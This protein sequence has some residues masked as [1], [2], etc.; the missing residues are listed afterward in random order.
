[1]KKRAVSARLPDLISACPAAAS[2]LAPFD[3]DP[4][5]LNTFVALVNYQDRNA[6][7]LTKSSA[8]LFVA[9][10]LGW[11]WKAATVFSVLPLGLLNVIVTGVLV[12]ATSGGR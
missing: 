12:V 11:P 9:K 6:R 4:S 1:M 8:A 3:I 7:A 10:T 5:D 2:R